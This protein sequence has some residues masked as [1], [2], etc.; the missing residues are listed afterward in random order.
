[1]VAKLTGRDGD[2]G[3]GDLVAEIGLSGLLHLSEDHGGD[4]FRGEV[5]GLALDLDRDD[6]LSTLLLDL[7]RP[8]L[9]VLLHLVLIHLATDKTF[10][11][12]DRV[13]GVRVEGVL[14][15]V[16]DTEAPPLALVTDRKTKCI[17]TVVPRQ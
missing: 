13:R 17:L 11:V 1:M 10:G 9:H 7:E 4:F 5:A 16:T 3:V 15:G 2:D 12:E 6:R 8:V 14:G